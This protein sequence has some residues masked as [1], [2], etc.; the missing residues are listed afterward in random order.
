VAGH[1]RVP[2]LDMGPQPCLGVYARVLRPGRVRKGDPV[3]LAP[4]TT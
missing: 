1:N 4:A 2:V 3:R